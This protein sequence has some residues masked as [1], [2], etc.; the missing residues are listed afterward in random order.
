[1][2]LLILLILGCALIIS[3]VGFSVYSGITPMPSNLASVQ[4]MLSMIPADFEG[5]IYDLGSGFGTLAYACARSCPKATVVGI[6]L[7][8][9]P[10][11]I[12]KICFR[13]KNLQFVKRNFLKMD[14]M[15]ADLLLCYLYPGG[16]EK[17]S[18]KA[19]SHLISN[20]FTLPGHTPISTLEMGGLRG[21]Q[22][23][24]YVGSGFDDHSHGNS[25]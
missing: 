23:F 19:F 17:L 10:Y 5:K 1:M 9:I 22:I 15:E 2:L 14:L 3:L 7:S 11:W 6:E 24:G 18:K 4:A 21:V 20:Y 16:M 25:R 8:P 13:R 12:S